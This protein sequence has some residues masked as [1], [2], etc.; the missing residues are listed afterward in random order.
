ME[1]KIVGFLPW[2]TTP[3]IPFSNRL[4]FKPCIFL[5][6]EL[7][8][9]NKFPG[10]P[11]FSNCTLCTFPCSGCSLSLQICQ[12]VNTNYC[13]AYIILGC[14]EISSA[15]A[16]NIDLFNLATDRFFGQQQKTATIFIK[17][18]QEMS[19]HYTIINNFPLWIFMSQTVIV[20]T[21]FSTTVFLVPA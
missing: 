7:D 4:F 18:S 12:R 15:N 19:L 2:G 21:A 17:I 1:G 3:F 20:H 8:T 14:L 9:N 6:T 16:I 11:F 10:A 5:S 13:M